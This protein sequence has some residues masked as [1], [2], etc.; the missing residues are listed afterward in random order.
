MYWGLSES[1]HIRSGN[2]RLTHHCKGIL[3]GLPNQWI[4]CLLEHMRKS[5]GIMVFTIILRVSINGGAPMAG[6]LIVENPVKIDDLRVL[7]FQET[8]K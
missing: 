7:P 5:T 8:S 6:W 2:S 3:K 4:I 1:N